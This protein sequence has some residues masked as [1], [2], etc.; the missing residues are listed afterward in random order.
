MMI[1]TIPTAAFDAA[2]QEYNE[3]SETETDGERG[4]SI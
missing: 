4:D 1:R 2:I 3:N